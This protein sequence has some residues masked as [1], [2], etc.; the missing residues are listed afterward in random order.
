LIA[1]GWLVRQ[2]LIMTDTPATTAKPDRRVSLPPRL[3]VDRREAA[4]MLSISIRALD[5]II[6]A[7]ELPAAKIGGRVIVTI[8]AL[9]QFLDS[10]VARRVAAASPSEG[11]ATP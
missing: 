9:E 7:G 3:A 4:E 5:Y 2:E 8:K 10:R 11:P 6:A 1:R